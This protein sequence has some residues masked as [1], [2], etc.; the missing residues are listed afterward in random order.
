MAGSRNGISPPHVGP[1][2][3]CLGIALLGLLGAAILG[4]TGVRRDA[5][6]RAEVATAQVRARVEHGAEE[7]AG[8]RAAYERRVGHPIVVLVRG[9][10]THPSGPR[11][12]ALPAT[13][14]SV[15]PPLAVSGTDLGGVGGTRAPSLRHEPRATPLATLHDGSRGRFIVNATGHRGTAGYG[16]VV[17]LSEPTLRAVLA[18][19]RGPRLTTGVPLPERMG[20]VQRTFL[21]VGQR[22]H[23]AVDP[24]ALG[25]TA[26]LLPWTILVAAVVLASLAAAL[27]LSATRRARAQEDLDRFFKHSR[28]FIAVIGLDGYFQ[29]VNPAAEQILGYTREELLSR[30]YLGFVH[31]D[32]RAHTSAHT[33]AL[34]HGRSMLAFENRV[35]RKDDSVRVLEWQVT[36]VAE[37]GVVFATGRDVTERRLIEDA[38]EQIAGEQSALRRVA[39]LIARGASSDRLFSAFTAEV[40]TLLETDLAGM[41]RFDG[42]GMASTMAWWSATGEHLVVPDRWPLD[43]RSLGASVLRT[44]RAVQIDDW[45]DMPGPTAAMTRDQFGVVSS[46]GS[47]IIVGGRSWG[48]LLVH[49]T[50]PEPLPDGTAERLGAFSELI[51]TAV[52]NAEARAEADALM[53]KHAALQ[54][55]ATLVAQA[56]TPA[57]VFDAVAAETANLLDAE[58]V[59]VGRYE[60]GPALVVLA[61]FGAEDSPPDAPVPL[62]PD[63]AEAIVHRTGRSARVDHAGAGSGAVLAAPIVVESS[64]WGVLTMRCATWPPP[65]TEPRLEQFAQLL[66]TAIA[67]ADSRDQLMASRARLLA[68]GDE[69]R[70]RV[71]RDLHDGA[72]QR[73]VHATIALKLALRALA[74]GKGDVGGLVGEALE[75]TERGNREL[76]ELAHGILPALLVTSGVGAA[77]DALVRRFDVRVSVTLTDDRFRAEIEASAYFIVA[78]ALT[79]VVKHAQA[80]RAEVAGGAEGGVLRLEISDDGIG[81]ADPG[82]EGLVGIR[83]RAAA[84]G[85]QLE[86]VSPKGKGTRL[87]VTLPL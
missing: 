32:D 14:V 76:R 58:S 22:F 69:A 77:I 44:G 85:G 68:A 46:I 38:F 5:E 37:D 48:M 6:Q 60:A 64:T 50:H 73:L 82:G 26:A 52:A 17:L 43:E 45:S 18:D 71:V 10:G 25:H 59:V 72:Q 75:H 80:S 79:N 78:E 63:C 33:E 39:T 84:L 3:L 62:D 9:R 28:D 42:D 1:A 54:R 35:V 31:P 57:A 67:N 21:V 41:A 27:G 24:Q 51:A 29:R 53:R 56:A 19:R 47:P 13:F 34:E 7:P 49:S 20:T 66:A 4:Q 61:H 16:A 87:T 2:V 55:V 8:R 11:D 23:L 30:P 12:G 65:G 15:E 36:P 86:V 74:T 70:R 81:G 83:D 40:G